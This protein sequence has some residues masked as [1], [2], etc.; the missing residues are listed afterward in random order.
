MKEVII[1][2]RWSDILCF[3][4]SEKPTHQHIHKDTVEWAA[5]EIVRTISLNQGYCELKSPHVKESEKVSMWDSGF[6]TDASESR[7]KNSESRVRQSASLVSDSASE[8]TD[9]RFWV[10]FH[11]AAFKTLD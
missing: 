8:L 6:R 4:D 5:S 7:G 10:P 11:G 3:I 1:P 9:F 2:V